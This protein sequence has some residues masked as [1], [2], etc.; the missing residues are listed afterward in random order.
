MRSKSES[1]VT[2]STAYI[3]LTAIYAATIIVKDEGDRFAKRSQSHVRFAF[4][5]LGSHLLTARFQQEATVQH[6]DSSRCRQNLRVS[7]HTQ[8]SIH[9]NRQGP[10]EGWSTRST[11]SEFMYASTRPNDM[12]RLSSGYVG[13]EYL[14]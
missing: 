14:L 4:M 10:S 1:K 12:N 5:R 8:R 3:P 7:G 2:D 11:S 9:H 6:V 13:E